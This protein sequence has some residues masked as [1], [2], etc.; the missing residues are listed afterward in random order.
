MPGVYFGK[1]LHLQALIEWFAAF[2]CI[3]CYLVFIPLWGM[4]G[5][6]WATCIG[7]ATLP[8]LTYFAS[9][10]YLPV[11]YDWPRIGLLL[12][13]LFA[14]AIFLY[15][16]NAMPFHLAQPILSLVVFGAFSIIAIRTVLTKDERTTFSQ[17]IR[18]SLSR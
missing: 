13:C 9:Q 4:Q 8:V 11:R 2:V 5:A 10:K 7:Y 18:G 1:K 6:A 3:V 16:L 12:L 17:M 14:T 15:L